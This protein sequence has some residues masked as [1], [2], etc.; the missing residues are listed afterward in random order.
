MCG[1]FLLTAPPE[2]LQELLGLLDD[3]PAYFAAAKLRP[4]FNV[5]PGQQVL[6]LRHDDEVAGSAAALLKWGLVPS[7]AKD[8]KISSR[9][10]NA[11]S[12]T[13]AE[14]PAFRA[15]FKRRRC[16][17]PADGFYEW[18]R[19]GK[20]KQP[21]CIRMR[22]DR[23]FAFAGLWERWEHP[24][25]APLETCTIL[26]CEPNEMMAG[27]HD[28]MPVILP[29]AAY[30]QWLDPGEQEAPRLKSLL[31]PCPTEEMRAFQVSTRVNSPAN[32]DPA[33]LE[34]APGQLGLI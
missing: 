30:Q 31:R 3:W 13:A 18:K 14:K 25:G 11:R 27:I 15:A 19:A 32:D 9:M 6:A 7:W 33:C 29:A 4:R 16:L 8:A 5:A 10:I 26:T 24:D 28:R 34:R 23:P 12:E 21:Y 2:V 22:D 1:R 20:Q 17:V